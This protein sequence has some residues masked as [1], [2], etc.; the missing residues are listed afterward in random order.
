MKRV[1]KAVQPV[2]VDGKINLVEKEFAVVFPSVQVQAE[3]NRRASLVFN[4]LLQD[5][6]L[7]R[8]QV[9]RELKKRNLWTDQDQLEFDTLKR[10]VLDYEYALD[11]G[12][13]K[14]SEA[15]DIALRMKKNRQR[16]IEMLS[17]RTE[18]DN[19]TCEGQADN[20]RFNYMFAHCLVYNDEV[21]TPYF[22]G[23]LEEY[24]QKLND[25][26]ATKGA[27]EF[28]YLISGTGPLDD[29]LPENKF[30]K[31]FNFIDENYRLIDRKTGRYINEDGHYVDANGLL[32]EYNDDGTYY[33]VDI[34]GRR[35]NEKTGHY[36]IGEPQPF[37]EDDGT[38]IVDSVET[39]VKEVKTA[40][41]KR[42]ST[43]DTTA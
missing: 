18:F 21:Q 40:K 16:M 10:E 28:Y 20:E 26:V 25:P 32:I 13:I 17:I 11:R 27:M 39:V 14:L 8:E 3:A 36:D 1:F 6:A 42:K 35:I 34:N 22:P 15:R 19:K 12:G 2:E 9:D 37:L 43:N 33:Y 4:R 41:S 29:N 30:L 7:V 38:P 24:N 5:G 23:G 31:K